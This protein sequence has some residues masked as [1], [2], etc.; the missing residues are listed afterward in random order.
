[1]FSKVNMVLLI[2]LFAGLYLLTR[3]RK[4]NNHENSNLD[5]TEYTKLENL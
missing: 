4:S 5:D 3:R 2:A 1:M